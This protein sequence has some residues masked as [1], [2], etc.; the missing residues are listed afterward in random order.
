MKDRDH[1]GNLGVYGRIILKWI[2][3]IERSAWTGFIWLRFGTGGG[4][5]ENGNEPSGPMKCVEFP[6]LL[7]DY[8]I[9][10]NNFVP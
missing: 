5:F 9:L 6:D 1:L 2:L 8:G 3:K 4:F 7:S 10:K